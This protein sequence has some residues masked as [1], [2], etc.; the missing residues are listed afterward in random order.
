MI[1]DEV[2]TGFGR[3]GKMF[4]SEH[5]HISPD[6]MI[7]G[8]A[9]TAGYLGHAATLASSEV[10]DS[11]LGDSYEKALMHGPTFMG[12]PLACTVALTSI[13]IFIQEN[14]L[15]KIAQISITIKIEF[16][17]INSEKIKEKRVIGAMGAIEMKDEASVKGFND[18]SLEN[19]IWL[20]SIGKVLYLM[21]PYIISNTELIGILEVMKSW[22][23]RTSVKTTVLL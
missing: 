16:S 23:K 6:I 3:T 12:N 20:R 7:L 10:F 21:P 19:G 17:T 5:A 2:A 22:I 18:F 14:Y 13:S 4:A 1:C 9:L 8:K 15:Q 11:F